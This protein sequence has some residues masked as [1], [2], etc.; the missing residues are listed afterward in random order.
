MHATVRSRV[1]DYFNYIWCRHGGCSLRLLLDEATS[2]TSAQIHLEIARPML[3]EVREG[4]RGGRGG[5]EG[6]GEGGGGGRGGRE[7]LDEATSSTS[8]Q[9]HLE[10][11]RPMLSEVRKG[12]REGGE[13]GEA[14]EDG[15]GGEGGEGGSYWTRRLAAPALR[16]TWR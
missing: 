13:V 7:L 3:S 6:G 1:E 10:I 15:E 11:A 16:Y 12:G 14:G 5:R 9:I 8:A 4:W 2:S